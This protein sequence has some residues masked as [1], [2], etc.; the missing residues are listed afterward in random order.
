MDSNQHK[1]ME[2][3]V[4]KDKKK[5]EKKQISLEKYNYI[6]LMFVTLYFL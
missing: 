1:I 2:H 6:D 5:R 3:V 4:F